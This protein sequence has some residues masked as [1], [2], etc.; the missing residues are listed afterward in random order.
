[1]RLRVVQL[2]AFCHPPHA[3]V[4]E[5]QLHLLCPV[6][7]LAYN[8]ECYQLYICFMDDMASGYMRSDG[9]DGILS[10][11]TVLPLGHAG[12]PSPGLYSQGKH[13]TGDGGC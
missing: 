10:I 12:A 1:M 9:A 8:V 3:G 7:M 5:V 6:N 2:V 11:H 4:R 13:K